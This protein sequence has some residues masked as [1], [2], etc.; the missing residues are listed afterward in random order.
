MNGGE[1]RAGTDLQPVQQGSTQDLLRAIQLLSRGLP[2]D[3]LAKVGADYTG[4]TPM[5]R[6]KTETLGCTMVD[7]GVREEL[8]SEVEVEEKCFSC[9]A[10]VGTV[11]DE[12]EP[13]LT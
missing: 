8:H 5:E 3:I 4:M 6:F 1:T 7:T 10:T 13:E 2:A 12:D 9:R 11:S